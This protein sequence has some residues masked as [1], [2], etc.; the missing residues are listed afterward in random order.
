MNKELDSKIKN[1]IN[2]TKAEKINIRELYKGNFITLLEEDYRLPNGTIIKRERIRKN[3]GKEAV[4]V[5]AKTEDDKYL[6]VV[7]NRIN[8]IVSV[9][10]P[11]GYVEENE[12]VLD[13]ARRELKEE[14]GYESNNL[15]F[16]ESFRT[17]LGIDGSVINVVFADNCHKVSNQELDESEFINYDLFTLEEL[18][19]L[20]N[21][22]YINGT[23]NRLVYYE[24]IKNRANSK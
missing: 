3:N 20:I 16:K 19:E 15:T 14:T 2:D 6:L 18:D 1:L 5:V 12:S 7:Q 13:A 11:A 9:E 8:G 4:I 23:G 17:A 21:S 10:F 22:H 24:L